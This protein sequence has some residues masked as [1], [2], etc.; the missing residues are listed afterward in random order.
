MGFHQRTEYNKLVIK[1]GN[2]GSEITPKGG[3]LRYGLI[4]SDYVAL[5]GTVPGTTNRL[6]LMRLAVRPPPEDRQVAP[7]LEYV[8]LASAQGG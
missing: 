2:N 3:F 7:K 5:K 6:V 4:N 1:I 8:S